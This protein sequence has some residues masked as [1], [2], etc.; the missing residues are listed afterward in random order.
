MDIA[1]VHPQLRPTIERF[2]P[3]PV[4]NRLFL[5]L[6]R[7][8]SALRRTPPAEAGITITQHQL[9]HAA[10]RI[11]RPA[12]SLS[13]AGLIWIHGG[14]LIMGSASMNDRECSAYAR[15]LQLVVVSVEYRLAP[16][17][18]FPAA[19]DDCFEVWQWL[20]A[21]AAALGIDPARIAIAGQSAGGGLSA[22]LVHRIHDTG[23]IQ[24]V[25]QALFCPML[26]DR[27]GAN[28][29]LDAI[30]HRI[31]NNTSNR[32]GWSWYLGHAAGT[33]TPPDYA[34]PARRSNLQGLPPCWIGVGDIDLFYAE[35]CDYA[36]RLQ[37]AGVECQLEVVAMAPHGFETFVP[38][39]PI[40]QAFM[41]NY[42]AFLRR[43]LGL[44][45]V[46]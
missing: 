24:P 39:A 25:A 46:T 17:H 11:Y 45:A 35:D 30:K 32:A 44:T 27:T 14:G 7:G 2:P 40:V 13:G 29:S 43:T 28:R 15:N 16:R 9:E 23:G 33:T 12:G 5:A 1:K 22:S 34:V 26:D 19:I 6:I 20:Q 37:A 36:Q 41:E 10:V 8:L 18:P 42:Y 31:W 4:H 21:N 3:F 38:D